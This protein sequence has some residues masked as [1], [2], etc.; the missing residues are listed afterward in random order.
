MP[1]P[2]KFDLQSSRGSSVTEPV[3]R[4]QKLTAKALRLTL[5]LALLAAVEQAGLAVGFG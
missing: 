1:S 4:R 5:V 2:R 3:G